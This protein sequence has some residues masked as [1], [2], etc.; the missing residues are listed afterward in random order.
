MNL[1]EDKPRVVLGYDSKTGQKK[2][3]VKEPVP[4]GYS[5]TLKPWQMGAIRAAYMLAEE[6]NNQRK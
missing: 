5:W 4:R 2:F 3:I 6:L 1:N